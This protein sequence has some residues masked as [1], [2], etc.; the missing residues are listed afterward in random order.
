[1]VL[2]ILFVLTLAS[3]RAVL[4]GNVAFSVLVLSTEKRY[5]SFLKKVFVFEKIITVFLE[6]PIKTNSSFTVNLAEMLKEATI[7]FYLFDE[8]HFSNICTL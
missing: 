4:Y 2:P 1:M 8:S 3:D 5:S 7:Q 6:K